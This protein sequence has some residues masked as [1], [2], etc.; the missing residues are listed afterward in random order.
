MKRFYKAF[1]LVVILSFILTVSAFANTVGNSAR[2][3]VNDVVS[4]AEDAVEDVV[5]DVK[6]AVT[7]ALDPENGKP[8]AEEDGVVD[9]DKGKDTS[10]DNN[11]DDRA[12]DTANE[13]PVT[14]DNKDTA[15]TK[16][17]TTDK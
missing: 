13:Q 1:A 10:L 5:T 7:D 16:G 17:E 4:G 9:D 3:G 15:D 6:D 12:G 14:E 2:E 11:E 8:E